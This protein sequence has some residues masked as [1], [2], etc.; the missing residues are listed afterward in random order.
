MAHSNS[1]V[2][3]ISCVDNVDEID[4]SAPQLKINKG[5]INNAVTKPTIL[6]LKRLHIA[7]NIPTENLSQPQRNVPDVEKVAPDTLKTFVTPKSPFLPD[8]PHDDEQRNLSKQ[9][10]AGIIGQLPTASTPTP[11]STSLPNSSGSGGCGHGKSQPKEEEL[12]P[13]MLRG[14][15]RGAGTM[16][17]SFGGGNNNNNDD[18]HNSSSS[19]TY[20]MLS[21]SNPIRIFAI[22]FL[23]H[24][25]Y[26]TVILVT[27]CAFV[28]S[29]VCS[30][31]YGNLEILWEL[32]ILNVTRWILFLMILL[33]IL[34]KSIARGLL[35]QKFSYLRIS[36]DWL[37]VFSL[38]FIFVSIIIP[39][40][41]VEFTAAALVILK[42]I[43]IHP[44][45]INA[46]IFLCS[47]AKKLIPVLLYAVIIVWIYGVVIFTLFVKY[48]QQ[49]DHVNVEDDTRANNSNGSTSDTGNDNITWG[50]SVVAI[51]EDIVTIEKSQ[52][53]SFG[54]S[55]ECL[56]TNFRS[57][58]GS[59]IQAI[60]ILTLR[61]PKNGTKT[62]PIISLNITTSDFSC[63]YETFA[64]S[65]LETLLVISGTLPIITM[66]FAVVCFFFQKSTQKSNGKMM[67]QQSVAEAEDDNYD[68]QNF[69]RGA[70]NSSSVRSSC[71]SHDNQL[72]HPCQDENEKVSCTWF[73]EVQNAFCDWDY[74]FCCLASLQRKL[75]PYASRVLNCKT[76]KVFIFVVL[77][78]DIFCMIVHLWHS[79]SDEETWIKITITTVLQ[80]TFGIYTI[81]AVVRWFAISSDEYWMNCWS[82]LD[83]TIVII[84]WIGFAVIYIYS[85]QMYYLKFSGMLM[86]R[87]LKIV[88]Y[89][90]SLEHVL[91]L[92]VSSI[93][94]NRHTLLVIVICSVSASLIKYAIL[95]SEIKGENIKILATDLIPLLPLHFYTLIDSIY[96]LL[97][98]VLVSVLIV[99]I[100]MKVFENLHLSHHDGHGQHGHAV[101]PTMSLLFKENNHFDDLRPIGPTHS[102]SGLSPISVMPVPNGINHPP[103]HSIAYSPS[104]TNG[105][106]SPESRSMLS[107][108]SDVLSP[109]LSMPISNGL[110]GHAHAH[111]DGLNLDSESTLPARVN[112]DDDRAST[113]I[114][115]SD[116][117]STETILNL[118]TAAVIILSSINII[119]DSSENGSSQMSWQSVFPGSSLWMEGFFITYIGVHI[120]YKIKL[121]RFSRETFLQVC[122]L[123]DLA[124]IL[125]AAV[126]MFSSG[127]RWVPLTGRFSD[128]VAIFVQSAKVVSACR[129]LLLF[130][131]ISWLEFIGAGLC[132]ELGKVLKYLAAFAYLWVSFCIT[133]IDTQTMVTEMANGKDTI[134][135]T[136][137]I[138]NEFSPRDLSSFSN[139]M[140]VEG[141]SIARD[142]FKTHPFT[143]AIT[144]L[145][146][147]FN[148]GVG[149][150]LLHYHV[151]GFNQLVEKFMTMGEINRNRSKTCRSH[152]EIKETHF[153]FQSKPTKGTCVPIMYFVTNHR[154]FDIIVMT[155]IISDAFGITFEHF[156]TSERSIVLREHYPAYM[157]FIYALEL[158]AKLIGNGFSFFKSSWNIF[159]SLIVGIA[160]SDFVAYQFYQ[161]WILLVIQNVRFLRILRLFQFHLLMERAF[162]VSSLFKTIKKFSVA[163]W[164]HAFFYTCLYGAILIFR[165]RCA[166]IEYYCL[167]N[168][169]STLSANVYDFPVSYIAAPFK[170]MSVEALLNGLGNLNKGCSFQCILNTCGL[171]LFSLIRMFLGFNLCLILISI[172]CQYLVHNERVSCKPEIRSRDTLYLE[173]KSSYTIPCTS[174]DTLDIETTSSAGTS[175][176]LNNASRF[177]DGDHNALYEES[178][179]CKVFFV[180]AMITTV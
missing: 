115:S 137:E 116:S 21:P 95:S 27:I 139:Y 157:I 23:T 144:I 93:L 54:L 99:Q 129:G 92:S 14:S 7:L 107:P 37:D 178:N 58:S 46:F 94:G 176:R 82:A 83:L 138:R 32:S 72:H 73:K 24:W 4:H 160:F 55:M 164:K 30:N 56:P 22:S 76:F 162:I 105:L 180:E 130:S 120:F 134:N 125:A 96:L 171:L 119:L 161:H 158:S 60:Q 69:Q 85:Y 131:R 68:A 143:I 111:A 177:M 26:Y 67:G 48:Q 159:D 1:N 150:G 122:A 174:P 34:I 155:I 57:L 40:K 9:K 3:K 52:N 104:D 59:F 2:H 87:M 49:H 64:L 12:D 169:G 31:Y 135:K 140:K 90:K 163:I 172:F 166:F 91:K 19:S 10:S 39:W 88:P 106:F 103:K 70:A 100:V 168:A 28:I 126:E 98:F 38:G 42:L 20:L 16:Q 43:P 66:S 102:L 146:L 151:G 86:I 109:L 165:Y 128:S 41:S 53:Y 89:W 77:S 175:S 80:I 101:N 153:N 118:T 113:S 148:L 71:S 5:N 149:L 110:N 74:Y 147:L 121:K 133:A 123:V 84:Y 18:S 108:S 65:I 51:V 81:D 167:L 78:V 132:Y 145:L 179:G 79:N 124:V 47:C 13:T 35:I 152:L 50:R 154:T 8:Y 61:F 173:D 170:T 112:S 156:A 127:M 141:E 25:I 15:S 62:K 29:S 117:Y 45:S 114:C 97:V 33:E 63:Q 44:G 17:H 75:Y 11:T 136:D 142:E 6:D 36:W